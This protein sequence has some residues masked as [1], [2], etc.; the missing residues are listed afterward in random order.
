[1]LQGAC[2]GSSFMKRN[3]TD[4]EI[5][6][7]TDKWGFREVSADADSLSMRTIFASSL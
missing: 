5:T 2:T 3:P 7:R 6:L 1:M 4:W